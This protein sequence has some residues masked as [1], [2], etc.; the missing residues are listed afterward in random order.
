MAFISA[1]EGPPNAG[2]KSYTVQYFDE[3]ENMTIR[4]NGT[5]AWR[6]NNPGNMEEDLPSDM[7]P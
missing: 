2:G 1:K 3:K 7:D 5:K 4:S 6:N